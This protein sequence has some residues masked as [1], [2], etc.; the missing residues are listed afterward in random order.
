MAVARRTPTKRETAMCIYIWMYTN[1]RATSTYSSTK[2]VHL[3]GFTMEQID[4]RD[5]SGPAHKVSA[6]VLSNEVRLGQ[7]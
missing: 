7:M 4:E 2:E 3:V 5:R 6:L 1:I